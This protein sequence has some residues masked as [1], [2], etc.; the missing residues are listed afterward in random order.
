MDTKEQYITLIDNL[1]TIKSLN[2][3]C[4]ENIEQM[5]LK[6]NEGIIINDTIFNSTQ[7]ENILDEITKISNVLNSEINNI[8]ALINE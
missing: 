1:E 2:S 6:L 8:N 7:I 4:T 3:K 5:K